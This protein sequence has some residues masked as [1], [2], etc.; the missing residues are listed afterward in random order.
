MIHTIWLYTLT[1]V[2]DERKSYVMETNHHVSDSFI[3]TQDM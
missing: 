1:Y 2:L 3:V